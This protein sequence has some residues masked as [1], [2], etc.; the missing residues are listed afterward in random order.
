MQVG[1]KGLRGGGASLYGGGRGE[2]EGQ[3]LRAGKGKGAILEVKG[4]AVL[5]GKCCGTA[6]DD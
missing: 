4:I 6:V 1:A 5:G 2:E 3:S